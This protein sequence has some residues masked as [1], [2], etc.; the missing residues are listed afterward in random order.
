M[1]I[2]GSHWRDS[3]RTPRFFMFDAFAAFPLVI[4]LLHIRWWTFFLA[5]SI[6]LFLAI[7]ERFKFTIPVFLRLIRGFFG[8]SVKKSQAWWRE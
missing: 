8:G 7:I 1:A 4:F 3:A 6:T 2:P 5:L